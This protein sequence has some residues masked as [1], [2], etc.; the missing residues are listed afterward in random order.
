[1]D[2]PWSLADTYRH[3]VLH[4]PWTEELGP[5]HLVRFINRAIGDLRP[6]LDDE[7]GI[8]IPV[9]GT[10]VQ[11]FLSHL[12]RLP[13]SWGLTR[14]KEYDEHGVEIPGSETSE[15]DVPMVTIVVPDTK[16][17]PHLMHYIYNQD[18]E[19]LLEQLCGEYAKPLLNNLFLTNQCNEFLDVRIAELRQSEKIAQ[20]VSMENLGKGIHDV[21]SLH[22]LADYLGLS[23]DRFWNTI[24]VAHR[25]LLDAAGLKRTWAT[26]HEAQARQDR[27]RREE[28]EEKLRKE[29]EAEEK[30]V[31][32]MLFEDYIEDMEVEEMVLDDEEAVVEISR[33]EF[34]R[35]P[36]G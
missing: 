31:E 1:M 5:T 22:S 32:D 7:I 11:A 17:V 18:Q 23:D 26:R 34:Y 2:R 19:L 36:R 35:H 27:I 4:P 6:V 20:E 24:H 9:H 13:R 14:L 15:G 12:D 33:R 3:F 10:I 30:V 21:H 29:N 25:V 8:Q 28:A 16:M